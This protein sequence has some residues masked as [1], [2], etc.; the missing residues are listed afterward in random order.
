ME[1]IDT[2]R[3][4][5]R[6]M[7]L[8]YNVIVK[9]EFDNKPHPTVALEFIASEA[10]DESCS[11]GDWRKALV[12]GVEEWKSTAG[13]VSCVLSYIQ[14]FIKEI[15]KHLPEDL[16]WARGDEKESEEESFKDW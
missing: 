11:E 14:D 12:S 3:L 15:K 9:L 8:W 7:P 1:T 13:P 6:P 10:N 2:R 5:L 4:V 16:P